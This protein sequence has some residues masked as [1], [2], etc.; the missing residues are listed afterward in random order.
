MIEGGLLGPVGGLEQLY[1]TT[2]EPVQKA[3]RFSRRMA[4]SGSGRAQVLPRPPRVW[5]CEIE[6][7]APHEGQVLD[8]LEDLLARQRDP[9]V[10]YPAIAQAVNML[11]PEASLMHETRW[12]GLTPG[13][14]RVLPGEVLPG[15]RFLRSGA[16]HPTTGWTHLSNIPVPH[17]RVMTASAYVTAFLGY[18]GFF[19]V[20]EL[21]MDG[22]TV[23]VH[24]AN[25]A[26]ADDTNGVSTTLQRLS[27]TFKTSPETVALTF[28]FARCS[29][30]VAPA[31][32]LTSEPQP[33]AVGRGC[34]AATVEVTSRTPL[35]AGTRHHIYGSAERTAF[36]VEEIPI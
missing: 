7:D 28:G 20:D 16:T 29:T 24:Q 17:S 2:A 13:G 11:D 19:W 4:L 26:I 18:N 8:Q 14:A 10:W 12:T 1:F 5:A 9:L 31:L 35:W 36:T 22:R 6:H 3:T 33:W 25:T 27:H 30:V 23:R 32:T 34:W 21:A 15:P